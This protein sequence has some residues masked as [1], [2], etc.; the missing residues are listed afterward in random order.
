MV[1]PSRTYLQA[2]RWIL[3]C[4][5]NPS[6]VEWKG[7]AHQA[8]LWQGSEQL[9]CR[10]EGSGRWPP[11]PV[12]ASAEG[13]AFTLNPCDDSPYCMRVTASRKPLPK[14]L[15][16][17]Y[18]FHK[19]VLI[20]TCHTASLLLWGILPVTSCHLL[21]SSS[22]LGWLSLGCLRSP[23]VLSFLIIVECRLLPFPSLP[24]PSSQMKRYYYYYF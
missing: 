12:W 13:P 1:L 9:S 16:D 10:Q 17:A 6:S 5:E 8:G 23:A 18:T 7:E 21:R 15:R 3:K 14:F 2:V 4:V 24:F 11:A 19:S 22:G 20:V